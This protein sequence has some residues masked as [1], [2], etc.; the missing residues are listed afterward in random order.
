MKPKNTSLWEEFQ[1]PLKINRRKRGESEATSTHILYDA[2]SWLDTGTSINSD[3]VKL[4]LWALTS[5]LNE[6]IESCK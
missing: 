1:N 2:P 5:P 6:I 4:V 3:A